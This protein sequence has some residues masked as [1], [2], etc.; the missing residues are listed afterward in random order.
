M[1]NDLVVSFKTAIW[2]WMTEQPPTS[3]CHEA[4]IGAWVRTS[5]DISAGLVPGYGMCTNM[6]NGGVKCG[7]NGPDARVEDRI[8]FYKRYCDIY[9][10][11]YGDKLDCYGMRPFGLILT[12]ASA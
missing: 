11:S 12:C 9:G 8:G 2:F 1:E 7:G 4:M 3:F 6:I 10:I 5:A